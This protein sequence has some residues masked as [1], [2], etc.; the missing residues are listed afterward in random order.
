MDATQTTM[1]EMGTEHQRARPL[2]V[3]DDITD[4]KCWKS[5]P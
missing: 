3:G 4:T 1:R 5:T 2:K